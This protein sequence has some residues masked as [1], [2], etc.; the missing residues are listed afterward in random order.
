M[1]LHHRSKQINSSDSQSGINIVDLMMWLVIAALM[2][3]TAIQS[4][5][6]YQQAAYTY[7]AKNDLSHGHSW[8]AGRVA[9]DSKVPTWDDLYNAMAVGDFK[10]SNPDDTAII[11]SL[12]SKYC[13]G[14]KAAHVIVNPVFYSTSD[15]PNDI[16]RGTEMPAGCGTASEVSGP[17]AT[18]V[19]TD[20]DGIPN[21]T[22][23]DIDGDG[24]LNGND[25][26][27]DGDGIPNASDPDIDGDGI[28][29]AED[30]T[31]YGVI[32]G[33]TYV[34]APSGTS[35]DPRVSIVSTAYS[36]ANTKSVDTNLH[37]DLT[38]VST[39]TGP[40]Y[41]ISYRL[42]CQLVDGSQFYRYGFL[43]T[44][45]TGKSNPTPSYNFSCPT[46]DASTIIGY[47]VGPYLG[48]PELTQN[49][50]APGP[51]NVASEGTLEPLFGNTVGT[52]PAAGAS[53]D[54]RMSYRNAVLD[55]TNLNVGV[56]IDLGN[57]PTNSN[58]AY[59]VANRLTCKLT[60]GSTYYQYSSTSA[61]YNGSSYPAPTYT[62]PCKVTGGVV[63]GAVV[64]AVG[65]DPA[66]TYISGQPGGGN[67]I[68]TGEQTLIG[69]DPSTPAPSG[70]STDSRVSIR[71][72]TLNGTANASV[73]VN[74]NLAG[75]TLSG[76]NFGYS[77][78]LTCKDSNGNIS[79]KAGGLSSSYSSS[80]APALTYT[81]ACPTGTTAVGY[82]VGP[83]QG[84]SAL[85]YNPGVPGPVNVVQGGQ[86]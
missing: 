84:T 63:I 1:R 28:P 22:D 49:A 4:I 66:L 11:A 43:W 15:A 36:T 31:P 6:Y 17:N 30:P 14:I 80:T 32:T 42:T 48:A 60:D 55:G 85:T 68:A 81:A 9:Y 75:T 83:Y 27:V 2:L 47:I 8:A 12:G 20:H 73:G 25:P 50:T 79:Y 29:N 61:M 56:K 21:T 72:V 65:S 5:G 35:V 70:T 67:V 40:Y 64:G 82:V 7:Q 13:I 51:V 37:I 45:Y 77:L 3:A 54:P 44:Q 53:V 71:K 18:P 69:N 41:G 26:D 23:P 52:Q 39:L 33:P 86:Q 76:A 57:Q 74:I 62:Y 58:V 38:G 46:T 16:Q 59:T 78:R 19:D 34:T 10:V 24:I